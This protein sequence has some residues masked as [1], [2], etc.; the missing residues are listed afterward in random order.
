MARTLNDLLIWGK[1]ILKGAGIDD[2][3]IS[4]ELLLC[5]ILNLSRSQLILNLKNPVLP[6]IDTKY[7]NLIEKRAAHVPLQYLIGQIEFYNIILKTDAR[8]LI[9][10]PET[11]MLVETVLIKMEHIQAPK[12]LDIGTGSG[13]I[14]IALAKNIPG[15]NVTGI[16]ISRGALELA[17]ANA[18]L[19]QVE[20][21]I[22]FIQGNIL[23]IDFVQ[24]LGLFDCA[25]SNPPYVSLSDRETLQPEVA[26]FE[27]QE[28]LFAGDDPLIFYKTITNNISYILRTG[29]LLAFEVGLGQSDMV[30]DLMVPAFDDVTISKDLTGIERVVTGV[31]AGVDKGQSVRLD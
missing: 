8:A 3:N 22:D 1:E 20:S 18:K 28:A 30:A 26:R 16:D 23:N 15:S 21:H 29:G 2:Y 17:A 4:S 14:A 9:P 19:N 25:V 5:S 24:S 10:R 6:E 12:L 31:Y 13:N 27:P 11:E 7:K